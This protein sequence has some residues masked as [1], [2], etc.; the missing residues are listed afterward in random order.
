MPEIVGHFRAVYSSVPAL[1]VHV[2]HLRHLTNT[3]IAR[4]ILRE[5][6]R[7]NASQARETAKLVGEHV[8][9]SLAFHEQSRSASAPVRPVLQYYCYLNLAVAAILAYRPTNFNQHGSHGVEDRTHALSTLKL[10]SIVVWVKRGAVPLFHSILSGVSLYGKR[11]RLGQL[12]AGFQMVNHE[13]EAEFGK[14]PQSIQV[15]DQVVK[16]MSGA[17]FSEFSFEPEVGGQRIA[18][19]RLKDAMPLLSS[20]YRQQPIVRDRIIYRSIA[21]WTTRSSALRIHKTNGLQLV[22]FGGHAMNSATFGSTGSIY[23]WRG[24][25]RVPLLPTLSS[26]L[27]MSFSLASVARYRPVLLQQAM[28]SPIHLLLDTFVQ[29]ADGVYLPALRNLLYREEIAIGTQDLV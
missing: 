14:A 19:K 4:N 21:N 5:R 6:F 8:G 20:D 26:I 9:Q 15:N 22:N 23:M 2:S 27:L 18:P 7:L 29:E 11:F 25:T 10:S 1:D 24:V 16:D 13:L 28:A 17:W 3:R 12:A